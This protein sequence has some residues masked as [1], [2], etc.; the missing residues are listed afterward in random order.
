[1]PHASSPEEHNVPALSMRRSAV[2][3]GPKSLKLILHN[4]EFIE[5]HTAAVTG[6]LLTANCRKR[7]CV[8]KGKETKKR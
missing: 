3:G 2:K 5:S 6:T 8:T 4:N 1:M 7:L